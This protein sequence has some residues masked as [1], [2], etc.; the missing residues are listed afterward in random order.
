MVSFCLPDDKI[1]EIELSAEKSRGTD[2]GSGRSTDG[3]LPAHQN[4]EKLNYTLRRTIHNVLCYYLWS[5][6]RRTNVCSVFLFVA[7]LSLSSV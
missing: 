5:S 7:E 1:V 3:G 2:R 4:N 6:R